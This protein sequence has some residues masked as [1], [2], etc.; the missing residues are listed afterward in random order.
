M[1]TTPYDSAVTVVF[2]CQR[3]RR[4]FNGV[5]PQL[6]RQI[7]VRWVTISDFRPTYRYT[8]ETV[9]NGDIVTMER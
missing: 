2:C 5:I 7:E 1:Q 3:S 9:Q 4:N 8:S 6:G